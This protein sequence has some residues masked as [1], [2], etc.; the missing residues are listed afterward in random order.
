MLFLLMWVSYYDTCT[1]L[2]GNDKPMI[3]TSE[4]K[5]CWFLKVMRMMDCTC[6]I[7]QLDA[8]V[9]SFSIE[10]DVLLKKHSTKM[11]MEIFYDVQVSPEGCIWPHFHGLLLII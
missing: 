7:N 5:S 3:V 10:Y 9:W 1:Y 2:I 4:F 6:V 8:W 11:C